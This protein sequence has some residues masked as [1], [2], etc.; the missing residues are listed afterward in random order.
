MEKNLCL[1]FISFGHEYSTITFSGIT[2]LE[3][4]RIEKIMTKFA[5]EGITRL[6]NFTIA[7]LSIYNLLTL[8]AS[9][10]IIYKFLAIII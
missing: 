2:Y 5:T 6:E 1:Y 7:K 4:Y 8:L 3:G 9:Q 10:I